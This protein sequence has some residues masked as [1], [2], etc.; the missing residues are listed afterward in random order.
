MTADQLAAY[1]EA[2]YAYWLHDQSAD[3]ASMTKA[4]RYPVEQARLAALLADADRL[5][6]QAQQ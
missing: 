6:E 4:D 1:R 2:A 5:Y 3:A